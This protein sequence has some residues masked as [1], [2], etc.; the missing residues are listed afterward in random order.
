LTWGIGDTITV[1]LSA[2]DQIT[3]NDPGGR[4]KIDVLYNFLQAELL[5]Q[6]PRIHRLVQV[7]SSLFPSSEA[8]SWKRGIVLPAATRQLAAALS[9]QKY[10]AVLPFVFSLSFIFRLHTPLMVL[11]LR[12]LLRIIAV[13][14]VGG[15]MPIRTIIRKIAN[16]YF[17]GILPEPTGDE[18]IPLYISGEQVK[19]ATREMLRIRAQFTDLDDRRKLL[20]VAPDTSTTI[21]RP[22]T[23]LLVPALAG[24]L[25]SQED[26]VVALLPSYADRQ[27]SPNL[28]QA[29]APSFPGRIVLILTE[30][31]WSLCELAA[32]VD[33]SDVLLTG[34]TGVM[35]LAAPMKKR[36]HV[37]DEEEDMPRHA[38]KII[39]F[40]AGRIPVCLAI[41]I[42]RLFL[43]EGG[44]KSG[45]WLPES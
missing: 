30:P 13:L 2:V 6:D 19:K 27:A 29:L 12:E 31:R 8:G 39:A 5:D 41:A 7:D 14:R 28:L 34:D 15:D 25:Q 11:P 22:P 16:T 45:R 1:G 20:L 38:V 44:K 32:F 33:Q 40:L 42:A 18:A 9:A 26:L 35:H 21:T 17:G 36:A 10:T 4:V 23:S 3:R 24:A 37:T 43:E